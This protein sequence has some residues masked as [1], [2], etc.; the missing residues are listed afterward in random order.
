MKLINKLNSYC[1]PFKFYLVTFIVALVMILYQN[2]ETSQNEFCIGNKR[3]TLHNYSKL[4]I[5]LAKVMGASFWLFI[6]HNLCTYNY[7]TFAWA[8]VLL[9]WLIVVVMTAYLTFQ[10][11]LK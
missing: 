11:V 6:L 4:H 9:P 8:I 5:I 10:G 1:G 3:C 7:K 2:L